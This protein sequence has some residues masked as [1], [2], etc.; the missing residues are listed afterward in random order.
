MIKKGFLIGTITGFLLGLV[1]WL[2]EA[3]SGILVY[4]LL[5]NVDFIP[6]VGNIAWP[7]WIEWLFHLTIAWAIGIT[8]VVWIKQFTDGGRNSRW[9]IAL[10]LSVMAA[11]TYFPLTE[12]AI[13]ETPSLTDS[14]AISLWFGA[15]FLFGIALVKLYEWVN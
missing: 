1:L 7:L 3:T 15:H 5:L 14:N 6:I 4:T 11:L 9:S 2:M 8:Y 10:L 13:K 12:L